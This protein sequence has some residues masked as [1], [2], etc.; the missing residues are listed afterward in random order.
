MA[1]P[2]MTSTK[3][4]TRTA[5]SASEHANKKGR[6]TPALSFFEGEV[7][8]PALRASSRAWEAVLSAQ[9]WRV[10]RRST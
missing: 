1:S 3:S 5:E 6:L 8:P 10:M 7:Q 2:G 4:A 9:S